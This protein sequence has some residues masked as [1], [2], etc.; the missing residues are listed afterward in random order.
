MI[1]VEFPQSSE[2]SLRP[3]HAKIEIDDAKTS[4]EFHSKLIEILN[5]CQLYL[6]SLKRCKVPPA[7]IK[8]ALDI[9]RKYVKRCLVEIDGTDLFYDFLKKGSE[10]PTL[11]SLIEY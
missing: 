5:V 3:P 8:I 4:H 9:T 1:I 10:I 6:E 11:E 7:E 2:G